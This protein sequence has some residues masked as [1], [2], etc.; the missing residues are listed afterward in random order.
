MAVERWPV[1]VAMLAGDL[2]PLPGSP[3][4]QFYREDLGSDRTGRL[5]QKVFG[6]DDDDD[7][8]CRKPPQRRAS[9][10]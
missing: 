10:A 6:C 5:L 8:K 2:E 3:G 4:R 9:P 1:M 7:G